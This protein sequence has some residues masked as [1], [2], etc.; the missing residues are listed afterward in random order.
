MEPAEKRVGTPLFEPLTLRGVTLR[1]RIAIS[2]MCMYASTDGFATDWH[3]VHLGSRAI[4]G[5]GIV[6]TEAAAVEPRGRISRRDLGIWTNDHIPMLRR[7]NDYIVSQGAVA[8]LQLAHAGRKGSVG[9]P[10]ELPRG[11]VDPKDGGWIPIA[12]SEER[13]MPHYPLPHALTS[14]EIAE[15]VGAFAAAAT[16]AAEAGFGIT[17]IH[18]AH[19]YL[20]HEF[21]SPLANHRSDEYGGSFENRVRFLLEVT[22][23]VRAVW[24]QNRPLFVRISATDWESGGWTLEDSIRL[25]PMLT[26]RG[27]DVIDVTSAGIGRSPLES[28]AQAPGYQ[29]G[30][31]E[32]IKHEAGVKT[33]SVG[34]ILSGK[35]AND[36]IAR[37]ASDLVGIG[38][39]ALGEPYFPYRAARELGVRL[40][41]PEH[42]RR[43]I[44]QEF[45]AGG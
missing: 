21:L 16:R 22:E 18:A 35:A 6:F 34:M 5:A 3:L 36:A 42:Y 24:P 37:D 8:A 13:D 1:N 31:A 9:A 41:W 10:W 20:L 25:A 12:P 17:E 23:A 38:R 26:Q 33:M 4:G 11:A 39:I 7:I 29:V 27:I 30:F 45:A 43:A 2:P 40:P 14:A 32:R 44:L 15:Q 28:S 19:G